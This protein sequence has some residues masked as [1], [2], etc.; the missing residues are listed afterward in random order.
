M[1]Q[2]D[3]PFLAMQTPQGVLADVGQPGICRKLVDDQIA[4][5]G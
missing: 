4:S 1:T 2:L 3:N 5:G